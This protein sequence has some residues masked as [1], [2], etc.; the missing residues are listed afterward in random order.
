MGGK[1]VW[2]RVVPIVLIALSAAGL[3]AQAACSG[4]GGSINN[5]GGYGYGYN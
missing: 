5:G 3:C 4:G 2:L 1:T